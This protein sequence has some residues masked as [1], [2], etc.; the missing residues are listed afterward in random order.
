MGLYSAVRFAHTSPPKQNGNF[1]ASHGVKSDGAASGY[2]A[3]LMG[4]NLSRASKKVNRVVYNFYDSCK[5][6]LLK[7]LQ[8]SRDRGL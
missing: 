2:F 7:E 3:Y 8:L 5:C 4:V 1:S 6:I